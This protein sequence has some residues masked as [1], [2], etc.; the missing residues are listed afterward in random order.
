MSDFDSLYQRSV[1]FTPDQQDL[2]F[3]ALTS[4]DQTMK[5]QV[6]TT[7]DGM[8]VKTQHSPH[9]HGSSSHDLFN[10]PSDHV[11]PGSGNLSF[12]DDS[13]F[14]DFSL[15]PDFEA[16]S[17]EALI[18][19]LPGAEPREKRKSIDGK[20]EEESGK[21][22]KE[23]EEKVAKKP[24]RKPLTSEPT[25]KRKAQN[26]AAQ[27]AF[28]ERK[29]KHLKDL[30]T[31][32]EDLEKASQAANH[33][34][35][36]LRAQ[37]ERL[38]VEL[39][40]YRKRLS[41]ASSG[42]NYMASGLAAG[43]NGLQTSRLNTEF[44]FDFPKFGDL[45]GAMFNNGSMT[46]I[47]SPS[48]SSTVSPLTAM[49][50]SAPG[51]LNRDMFRTHSSFGQS[52]QPGTA[53]MLG[54]RNEAL[55][56]LYGRGVGASQQNNPSYNANGIPVK[57]SNGV[58][59][60]NRQG[61]YSS[62]RSG[63]LGASNTNSPSTSSESHHAQSSSIGTSP[64][65]AVNSPPAAKDETKRNTKNASNSPVPLDECEKSFYEKLNEACGCAEDPV[66]VALSRQKENSHSSNQQTSP[67]NNTNSSPG[68]NWLVQ[69]NG[70]QFDPVL[71]N[72]Y[73]EPQ[74]A[75]L[76]QEFGSFFNDAFPLPDLSNSFPN[77][78]LGSNP[79]PKPDLISQIE[80]SV[81][82]D[83]EVVPGEDRSQMLSCTKIW[84]R[85]QSME[86]FR[87]GEIDVDSL[88][89]ELRT[90]ARCSEGGVVVNKQDVEDIMTRAR[91][92]S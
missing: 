23:N 21:K 58:D 87:N 3:A 76:S 15:D 14:L 71:F 56:S 7:F 12:A 27:R 37:I 67:E 86:K 33:E 88:C 48:T 92:L 84:D 2:L 11:A 17:G 89:T 6:E 80:Q 43:N 22:R 74:D 73:R 83:E 8:P 81:D 61:S 79:T 26:R 47:Q 10:S 16:G 4:P 38:Q 40:E 20:E 31:K 44:S 49:Q 54:S 28:R 41:W 13:P 55:R 42:S 52:P 50:Y 63:P 35:S 69:Q 70:G 60:A 18:G 1:F 59:Q 82:A 66:P 45:P 53:G 72:D 39:R 78:D 91:K 34:N 30:E 19:D 36:L 25:S 24:G 32:V 51:V 57:P 75:V 9:Q 5:P 65:P 64:E 85:L 29:E 62:H 90:K 77:F 68:L 46:K